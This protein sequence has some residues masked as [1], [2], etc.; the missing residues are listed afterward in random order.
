MR[1]GREWSIDQEAQT[2]TIYDWQEGTVGRI[3]TGKAMITSQGYISCSG[4]ITLRLSTLVAITNHL[5]RNTAD[6]LLNGA[7][8]L[9][10]RTL[11]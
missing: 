2:A 4:E 11:S 7:K 5:N 8:V 9:T 6:D 1:S 10:M 3:I